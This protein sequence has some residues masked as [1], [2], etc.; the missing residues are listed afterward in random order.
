MRAIRRRTFRYDSR[1]LRRNHCASTR[2]S[3]STEKAISGKP[4]VHPQQRHHDADEH[5]QIAERGD[6][7]RR[8]QI[9]DDV[10]VGGHARHQPADGIPVVERQVE[11]LQMRVNLHA[12]VEHDALADHLHHVGLRVFERE[13]RERARP[14]RRTRCC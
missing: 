14:G 3:G 1:T 12:H 8:E 5:E 13:R 9:V 4:P 6:D 2:I 11:P 7:A 10:D